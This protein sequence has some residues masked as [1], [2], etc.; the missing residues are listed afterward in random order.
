[1]RRE[2]V[3]ASVV[4]RAVAGG[5]GPRTCSGVK[6]SLH[7]DSKHIAKHCIYSTFARHEP[8]VKPCPPLYLDGDEQHELGS[9]GRQGCRQASYLLHK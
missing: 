9:R 7:T 6:L 4:A 8:I 2:V 1:M 5:E 3:P